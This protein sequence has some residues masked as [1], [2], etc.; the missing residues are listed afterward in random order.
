[1]AEGDFSAAVAVRGDDELGN[2]T[3]RFNRMTARLRYFD[4]LNL[5]TIANQNRE[6][7][8]IV[9]S[10]ADGIV[11]LSPD[12]RAVLAN[13]AARRLL[14]LG[15]GRPLDAMP[16]KLSGLLAAQETSA[17]VAWRPEGEAEPAW[18]S[19]RRADYID[20]GGKVLG[21]V[22]ALRDV[23]AEKKLE[24]TRDEYY[25]LLTHDLRAPLA[26]VKSTVDFMTG[27]SS[28]RLGPEMKEM[29]DMI[30]RSAQGMLRM[31][32]EVLDLGKAEAGK[33]TVKPR[34]VP[35][36]AVFERAAE[37]LRSLA[38]EKGVAVIIDAPSAIVVSADADYAFRAVMNLLSNAIKFTDKGGKVELSA[39][40]AVDGF[41]LCSVRDNGLGIPP[42]DLGRLFNKYEQA[43][44]TRDIGTGLGLSLAKA[45][46]EAH[47]GTIRVES[48]LGKGSTFSFTLPAAK[49]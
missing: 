11:V 36:R 1:M 29:V 24:K 21:Q 13:P 31:I 2:L 27:F 6:I 14:G 20:A 7:Q 33:L 9:D 37:A 49:I 3:E 25:S 39:A 26:S 15:D 12:G 32:S 10:T 4:G 19:V 43:R 44:N 42:E 5:E 38:A 22:V 30:D 40:P 18:L 45:V 46:V 48:A 23:T 47:G 17:T 34:P 41:V 8:A 16:E 28:E 35:A